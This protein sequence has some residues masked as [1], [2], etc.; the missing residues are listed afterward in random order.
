M[1]SLLF[2]SWAG[3]SVVTKKSFPWPEVL[4]LTRNRTP[5]VRPPEEHPSPRAAVGPL[6][7]LPH[8][9]SLFYFTQL[10][11]GGISSPESYATPPSPPPATNCEVCGWGLRLLHTLVFRAVTLVLVAGEA[12]QLSILQSQKSQHHHIS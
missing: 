6:C 2:A 7:A 5:L 1:N 4:L 10:P 8:L 3:S 12:F 11:T 9:F